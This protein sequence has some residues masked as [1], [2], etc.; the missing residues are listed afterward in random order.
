MLTQ[1][2]VN[3]ARTPGRYTDHH[4]L[5]LVVITPDRRHWQYRFRSNGRDR[6]MS[7]GNADL[8]TLAIA[9]ERHL[10]ARAKLARGV[11]PLD[12]RHAGKPPKVAAPP[13]RT[14]AT[15]ARMYMAAH[16]AAWRNEQHRWQWKQTLEER[17]YPVI[18]DKGVDQITTDDMLAILEPVWSKTPETASRLRGRI[19]RILDYARVRGWRSGANPAL[20]RGNLAHLLPSP[21]KLHPVVH[22]AALPWK[23]C[24]A[25]MAA[26]LPQEG[27]MGALALALQIFTAA[28]SGEVRLATWHEIDFEEATWIVPAERM[29]A[30]REHRVPLSA[31]ALTLLQPLAEYRQG[32]LIFPSPGNP[33]VPL[34]NVTLLAVLK[35]M[36]RSDITSHGFRSSF[37]SW[38]QDHGEADNLAEA[39]LAHMPTSKVVAAYARSDMLEARRGLMQRWAAFLTQPSASVVPLRAA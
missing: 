25:F 20:W 32:A 5:A 16:E 29:K 37:R 8:V 4:G 31:P 30:K 18:G 1:A 17:A 35:R 23:Q 15:V 9:R 24:P 10:E 13:T 6:L 28:R 27:S 38:C 11:D 14:F 3:T 2:F 39:A 26:L 19:E 21:L 33:A 12:E 34:S 7:L 36:G 22:H